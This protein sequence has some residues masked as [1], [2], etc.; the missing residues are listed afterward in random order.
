MGTDITTKILRM[1]NERKLEDGINETVITLIPKL[2]QVNRLD[3]CTPIS[4]CNVV[5]KIISKVISNRLK[6]ILNEIV[7]KFQSAFIPGR[8]ISD[9][10]L[11]AHEL[12][13]FIR[14]RRN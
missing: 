5:Y 1:L 9:I 12:S 4:L 13:Y 10:F 14:S 3:D 2:K 11:L 6:I 7:S 8:L